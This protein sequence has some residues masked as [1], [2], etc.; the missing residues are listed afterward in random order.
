MGRPPKLTLHPASDPDDRL[1]SRIEEKLHPLSDV[2]AKSARRRV[3]QSEGG[4]VQLIL[5]R[6]DPDL[7]AITVK[8]GQRRER[9][10]LISRES[11]SCTREG[12][13]EA[14]G[15]RHDKR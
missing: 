5:D 6:R 9:N 7:S 3:L 14:L 4:L 11:R 1:A 2:R 15:L 8:G 13:D 12:E 10:L